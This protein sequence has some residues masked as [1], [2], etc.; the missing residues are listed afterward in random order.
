MSAIEPT[1][2]TVIIVVQ[3]PARGTTLTMG[4]LVD[5]VLEVL[6]IAA[7]QIEPP[8]SFG[9]SGSETEFI[10]GVGKPE[11]RVVFLLDVGRALSDADVRALVDG[12]VA[13]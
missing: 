3:C 2:Q 4:I 11:K 10:L 7:D 5:Q 6:S 12:T 1:E 9:T 13:A 8:P